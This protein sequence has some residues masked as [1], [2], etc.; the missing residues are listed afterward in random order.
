MAKITHNI[1]FPNDG[2]GDA[3][4][5]A[6]AHQNDMNTE[7]YNT[8]VN[9]VDGFGLS[10]NN[11]TDALLATIESLGTPYIPT[12]QEVLNNNHALDNGRSVEGFGLQATVRPLSKIHKEFSG[13]TLLHIFRLQPLLTPSIIA[14]PEKVKSH[15]KPSRSNH[16]FHTEPFY[17]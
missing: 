5:T 13:Q 2:L 8:K 3:L 4:R 15:V 16:I 14:C 7:L 10:E 12:L 17:L 11:L 6:M 1:S 9:N